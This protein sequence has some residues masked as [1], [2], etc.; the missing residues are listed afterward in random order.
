MSAP[1]T[2]TTTSPSATSI[3]R[4][5]R[6]F[7]RELFTWLTDL[8]PTSTHKI[9]LDRRENI[10]LEK[11]STAELETYFGSNVRGFITAALNSF[12]LAQPTRFPRSMAPKDCL[13]NYINR[14]TQTYSQLMQ[15]LEDRVGSMD[16]KC[17]LSICIPVAATQEDRHI[18]RTLRAFSSQSVGGECFEIVLLL[19]WREK[20]EA[21]GAR[22]ITKTLEEIEGAMK[23][24][25]RLRVKT[26]PLVFDNDAK[27]TIG[28]LRSIVSDLALIRHVRREG[29]T[30]HILVRNDADTRGVDTEY[31]RTFLHR[32]E[33]APEVDGFVGDLRWSL[34][35]TVNDPLFFIALYMYKACEVCLRVDRAY[36]L[37]GGPNFAVR[38]SRY[39]AV[40]GYEDS[41]SYAECIDFGWKL[42][43]ARG[44]ESRAIEFGGL[45]TRLYTSS[46]RA[47]I[48][49]REQKMPADQWSNH[50]TTFSIN[51]SHIRRLEE[52]CLQDEKIVK[53]S[54]HA[55]ESILNSSITQFKKIY[56]EISVNDSTI[57]KY[58]TLI[59][60]I[61]YSINEEGAIRVSS[62]EEFWRRFLRFR[63]D[64][65]TQ[66]HD[67]LTRSLKNVY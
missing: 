9:I 60:G 28:L 53:P 62:I 25:P 5:E 33:N 38:A 14:W 66:Q 50:G 27:L 39:A 54:L 6:W 52:G 1:D 10:A 37:H 21:R 36:L 20:D 55:V 58:L 17:R 23:Q 7:N 41:I 30:D 51:N 49:F 57:S 47:E 31:V 2:Y 11:L 63:K 34:G 32:F 45:T 65:L 67:R 46:R 48:A 59:L 13:S 24:C 26:V 43:D 56:P 19:N 22:R 18:G 42:R 40:G 8:D 3:P 44:D 15:S 12:R 16:P 4:I 61:E 35:R 64:G 29:E